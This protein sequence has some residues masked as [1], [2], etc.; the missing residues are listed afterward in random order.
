MHFS[1]QNELSTNI[2]QP[3]CLSSAQIKIM[4]HIILFS[5]L[6][7]MSACKS[8]KNV[9]KK[10]DNMKNDGVLVARIGD[11]VEKNDPFD[12]VEAK[13]VGNYLMLKVGYGGGCQDHEFELIGSTV[14]AKSMPAIR[15]IQIV[16]RANNDLCKAYIYK[17]LKFDIRTLSDKQEKD[18]KIYLN[19]ENFKEKLLY[20]FE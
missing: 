11:F 12:L 14:I 9:S 7:L 17:D 18:H 3:F 5:L 1:R 8:S 16:H 15:T 13:I 2:W 20:T 19:N 4:K 6:A 10:A